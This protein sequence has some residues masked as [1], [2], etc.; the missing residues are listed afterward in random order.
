MNFGAQQADIA[1]VL[2]ATSRFRTSTIVI[3]P[4][5]SVLTDGGYNPQSTSDG[6]AVMACRAVAGR[7]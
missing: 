3:N 4:E 1:I 5:T 6:L 7:L 2:G